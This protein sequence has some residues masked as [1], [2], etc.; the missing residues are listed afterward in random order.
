M[1]MRKIIFL[2]ISSFFLLTISR[3]AYA[4]EAIG[5]KVEPSIIEKTV[6]GG[7]N[8][9]LFLRIHNI[10]LD[11]QTLTL[12]SRDI[13][14]ITEAGLPIFIEGGEKTGFELSSWL[15]VP[16]E[17]MIIAPG[18]SLEVPFTVKVPPSPTPGTH[19]GAVFV[20]KPA[21]RPKETGI[22]VGYQVATIVNLR[23]SGEAN[24]GAELIEFRTDKRIYFSPGVKFL[25]RV[26]NTGNLAVKPYGPVEIKD[27]FGKKVGVLIMNES[28]GA[29]LPR[30]IRQYETL[31]EGEGV[32]FGRYQAVLSLLYGE[33][34]KRTISGLLNFWILPAKLAL[35]LL[36]GLTILGALI[37]VLVKLHI[38]KTVRK[39]GLEA[40]LNK[41]KPSERG[42]RAI[43]IVAINLFLI[44]IFG[45]ALFLLFA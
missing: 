29:A 22:G 15:V 34:S 28:A 5:V 43:L 4:Q 3:F 13:S 17:S 30:T 12:I 1:F 7:E 24:E 44:L 42:I 37:F 36:G 39:L 33:E 2:L 45:F 41:H 8:L 14:G 19:I 18:E 25:A 23:V 20:V 27:M 16:K 10:S 35:S 32:M 38:R 6:S 11:P 9:D 26:R 31:W 40:V 21:E